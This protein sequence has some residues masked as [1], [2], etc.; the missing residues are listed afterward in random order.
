MREQTRPGKSATE[1]KPKEKFNPSLNRLIQRPILSRSRFRR[2][3]ASRRLPCQD[4]ATTSFNLTAF[5]RSFC[6]CFSDREN[7]PSA[8]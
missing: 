8:F 6:L 2:V 3:A 1:R 7:E 5:G 4:R